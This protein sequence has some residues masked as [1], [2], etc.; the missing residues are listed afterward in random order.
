[1]HTSTNTRMFRLDI[2]SICILIWLYRLLKDE[3]MKIHFL[4]RYLF[5]PHIQ[6]MWKR[7]G[8]ERKSNT[9]TTK[10]SKNWINIIFKW[11]ID[12][13]RSTLALSLFVDVREK[14]FLVGRIS[15]PEHTL[16]MHYI[17]LFHL[18][19]I[20]M[21]SICIVNAAHTHHTLKYK[22][23]IKIYFQFVCMTTISLPNT[24]ED[25]MLQ[26]HTHT[27]C[28]PGKLK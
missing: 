4:F 18:H 21:I 2:T 24:Y 1:M 17:L 15:E 7:I 16:L 26:K 13:H 25:T 12:S 23:F 14:H 11:K 3:M 8:T 9:T 20:S 6:F 10:K 19:R 22:C 5:G 28:A 27:K